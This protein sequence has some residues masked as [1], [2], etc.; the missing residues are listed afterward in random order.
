MVYA[1]YSTLLT[2]SAHTGQ[3]SPPRLCTEPGRS[4]D[5]LMSWRDLSY[6]SDSSIVELI[7]ACRARMSSSVSLE[8]LANGD[9]PARWQTSLARRRP[10]PARLVWS[11]R[12]PCTR[13]ELDRN[14]AS[15]AFTGTRSASGPSSDSG[16]F[17][18]LLSGRAHTPALFSL[19]ASLSN[20]AGPPAKSHRARPPRGRGD[21]LASGLS[22]PPCM[23]CTANVRGLSSSSRYLPRLVTRSS[24]HPTAS[25]GAGVTVLSA[26]NDRARKPTRT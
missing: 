15:S 14:I 5:E 25:S 8:V 13:P 4:F 3:D 9:S 16:P 6:A 17:P 2:M 22:R 21:L 18:S 10:R 20:R 23:R 24:A 7:E 12:K 19:P 1:E 26:V 11:R